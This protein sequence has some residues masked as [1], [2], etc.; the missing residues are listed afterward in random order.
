MVLTLGKSMA[1]EEIR[2]VDGIGVV[3]GKA[4]QVVV[5]RE[6]S[7]KS[8]HGLCIENRLRPQKVGTSRERDFENTKPILRTMM[9]R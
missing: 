6:V 7:A 8:R 1:V 3:T 2:Q 9:K 4:S 5:R